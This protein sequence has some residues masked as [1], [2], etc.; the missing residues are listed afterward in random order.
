MKK[1]AVF[2]WSGGKD[3]AFALH[4]LL[5]ANEYEVIS[6]L[7]TVNSNTRR[8]SMH[9]IPVPLLQA[10]ADSIGI[11]L[12]LIEY[13]P[14]EEIKG[15]ENCMRKAVEDFKEQGVSHFV[16]GDIF[17]HDVRLYREKQLKPYGIEVVE[18]LW[19]MK[20]TEVMQNFLQSDLK[21]IVVTTMA[22]LL[23]QSYIGR[24]VD[25]SFVESLPESIDICGENGEYHTFCFDGPIFK[26]PIPYTLGTPFEFSHTVGM[27]DGSQQT[28]T[29]WFADINE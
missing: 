14:E 24:L 13:G 28:F 29:Y 7:T 23:D 16:F 15:Y 9:A 25:R 26:Y 17:L 3:S 20:S 12:Y 4:K 2:N 22:N 10:Q 27:E 19:E 11:P 18:P 21:T 8:S 1:K 6:L 5:Q